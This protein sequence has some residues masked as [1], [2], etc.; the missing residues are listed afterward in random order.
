MY[1]LILNETLVWGLK[2]PDVNDP[3]KLQKRFK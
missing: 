1:L 2:L 3:Q